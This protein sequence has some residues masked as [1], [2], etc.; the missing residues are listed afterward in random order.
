MDIIGVFIIVS[1]ANFWLL[2]PAIG[3]VFL[4]ILMRKIYVA[5]SRDI[6]R[7]ESI[8]KYILF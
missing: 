5:S 2:F 6:K 1:I 3:V 4:L 7:I 8:C